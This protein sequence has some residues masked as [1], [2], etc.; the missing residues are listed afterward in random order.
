MS[1]RD[2]ISDLDAK[3]SI[4]LTGQFRRDA[5]YIGLFSVLSYAVDYSFQLVDTFWVARLGAGAA[6]ALSLVTAIIYV[7]M[8]FNEIIGV[9]SVAVLSQADGRGKPEEFGRLFWLVLSLKLALGLIFVAAFVIYMNYGFN[10]LTDASIKWY[11][12]KYANIIWP[13]LIIIPAY[14]TIMTALRISGQAGMAAS[15]SIFAFLSNFSLVPILAFGHLG[16][17]PLGIS[18]A[19]WATVLAQAIVLAVAFFALLCGRLGPAIRHSIGIKIDNTMLLNLLFIGLPV[20]G[21]MLIGNIEQALVVAI[22]AHQSPSISD[23]LSIASRLSGFVYMVNFGV[24]AGVSITVGKFVGAGNAAVIKS[25]LP[26][27]AAQAI[28]IAV[29]TSALFAFLAAPL[30]TA[31]AGSNFSVGVVKIYL[32]FMVLVSAGNCCFLVYGGV[33]EGF[34]KNWPVFYAA[35]FGHVLLEGPLLLVAIKGV[36]LTMLWSIVSVGSITAAT[37]VVI[38]CHRTLSHYSSRTHFTDHPHDDPIGEAN[39]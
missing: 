27:F 24:A 9:S 30:V 3:Q 7:V 10:W 4:A 18:G 31:F 22:V 25:A 39:A 1:T 38:T 5:A 37:F 17:P 33:Y 8:A 28:A 6:T 11:I 19:A 36:H 21:V 29:L 14:S 32:W 13:T 23:G 35:L 2:R 34:G 20:G 15:L 16:F 12:T 26:S